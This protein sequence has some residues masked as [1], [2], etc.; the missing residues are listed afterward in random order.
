MK[1]TILILTFALILATLAGCGRNRE[2]ALPA[3]A[4]TVAV[5]AEAE[6]G[7]TATEEATEEA[8]ATSETLVEEGESA[9]AEVAAAE[10][11]ADA[12]E[13]PV[14]AGDAAQSPMSPLDAPESPLATPVVVEPPSLPTET[15]DGTGAFIGR[16]MIN[17]ASGVRPV[18]DM[19]VA[20]AD[21]LRDEDGTP[22]IAGYESAVARKTA[23]DELGRFAMNNVEPGTYAIILDA[24]ITSVLLADPTTGEPILIEVTDGDVVDIGRLDYESLALPNYLE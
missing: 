22:L 15:Q 11:A 5:P 6:T 24:V 18:Q 12:A 17:N 8:A 20:L 3:P 10:A 16:I 14:A 21:V 7:E 13:S 4:A 2:E 1:R 19:I 23:T 9:G